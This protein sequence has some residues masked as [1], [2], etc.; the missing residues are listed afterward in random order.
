MV[1]DGGKLTSPVK[2][3]P[4]SHTAAK[5]LGTER[6][7]RTSDAIVLYMPPSI[8][9]QYTSSY[10]ESEIGAVGGGSSR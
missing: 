5:E 1:G 4:K 8:G 3:K 6:T 10:K 7:K 2:G 9:V